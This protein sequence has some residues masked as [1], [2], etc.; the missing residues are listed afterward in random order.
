MHDKFSPSRV[1]VTPPPSA[2][3]QPAVSFHFMDG[4][5]GLSC[6]FWPL[7]ASSL[8]HSFSISCFLLLRC[9]FSCNTRQKLSVFTCEH[10]VCLHVSQGAL[11]TSHSVPDSGHSSLAF[12]T[13]LLN[14]VADH[15][16]LLPG[17]LLSYNPK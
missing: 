16:S 3:L 10:A 14:S 9:H 1:D 4:L 5:L 8:R 13:K 2:S 11:L 7:T 15:R 6:S 17:F 12:T